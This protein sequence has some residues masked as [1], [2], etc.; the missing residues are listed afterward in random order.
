MGRRSYR[1]ENRVERDLK[2]IEWENVY[3]IQLVLFKEIWGRGGGCFKSD[4]KPLFPKK[5]YKIFD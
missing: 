3:W 4:N 5:C 2:D 1:R